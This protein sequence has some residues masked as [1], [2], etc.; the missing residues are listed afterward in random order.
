MA[1]LQ[2]LHV[3]GAGPSEAAGGTQLQLR[4][5]SHNTLFIPVGPEFWGRL[6]SLCSNFNGDPGDGKGLPSRAPIPSDAD[7][8]NAWQ[9]LG[10]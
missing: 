5:H 2:G 4:F 9:T 1:R 7:F 3:A 10:S 8:S 6:C